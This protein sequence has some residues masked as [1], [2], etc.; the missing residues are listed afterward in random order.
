MF[1][2]IGTKPV[3]VIA[4]QEGQLL[5][6]AGFSFTGPG[7][8]G[9]KGVEFGPEIVVQV[10]LAQI[11]FPFPLPE[12]VGVCFLMP[13]TVGVVRQKVMCPQG[14]TR[15]RLFDT[16]FERIGSTGGRTVRINGTPRLSE[17]RAGRGTAVGQLQF[18]AG[19][20]GV[21]ALAKCGVPVKKSTGVH[22]ETVLEA[23]DV[24]GKKQQ[25]DIPA[26]AQVAVHARMAVKTKRLFADR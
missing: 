23:K 5:V 6:R 20:K 16:S 4:H 10:E 22:F 26:A 9:E 12:G 1:V 25:V 3:D 13:L 2:R 15:T 19:E 17:K 24:V 18:E 14:F 8:G 7:V 11:L 21:A